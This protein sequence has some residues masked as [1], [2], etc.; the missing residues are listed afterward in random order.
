MQTL[1]ELYRDSRTLYAKVT[2]KRG[3]FTSYKILKNLAGIYP[4]VLRNE[5]PTRR[6]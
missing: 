6:V 2:G 1:H 5:T 3:S 4:R